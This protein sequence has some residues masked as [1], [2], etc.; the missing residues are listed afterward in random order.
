VRGR[1]LALSGKKA[2]SVAYSTP[3]LKINDGFTYGDTTPL[4]L[5]ININNNQNNQKEEEFKGDGSPVKGLPCAK[6]PG[7]MGD[8]LIQPL[9]LDVRKDKLRGDPKP[10]T[11]WWQIVNINGND[12][13]RL[14][15]EA[16]ED[17]FLVCQYT[18]SAT[19]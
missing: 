15:P 6:L 1:D 3:F 19:P 11:S 13:K 2:D 7:E 16:I 17:I 9:M 4:I 8:V 10:A 12:H 5:Y 14:K 18:V